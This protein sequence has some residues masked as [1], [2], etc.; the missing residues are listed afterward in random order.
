MLKSGNEKSQNPESER[1]IF[2]RARSRKLPDSDRRLVLIDLEWKSRN[3]MC[4]VNFEEQRTREKIVSV[5][6]IMS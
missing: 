6:S 4:R 5:S 1:A 3:T 2:E